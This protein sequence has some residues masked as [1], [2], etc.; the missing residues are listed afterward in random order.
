MAKS[1]IAGGRDDCVTVGVALGVTP[2][3]GVGDGA[4]EGAP[5]AMGRAGRPAPLWSP[6]PPPLSAALAPT[7]P[8]PKIAAAARVGR[9]M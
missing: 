1:G 7:P 8:T 9:T 5:V 3:A 4:L 2:L 6:P